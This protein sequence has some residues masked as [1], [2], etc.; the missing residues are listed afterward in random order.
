M[1]IQDLRSQNLILLEVISGSKS[2][3]LDTPSSDT[4]IKGVFY[5]PKDKF[6]GLEYIPQ[7]SNETNDIVYYELGRF[8]ELLLKN[9]PN[10]LEILATPE[11]CILYK[12]PIMEQLRLEDFLSKLCKD[13]FTG[14]AI[15]Q[16]KKA[17]TLKKKIV[18]PMKKERKSLLDFCFIL[19]GPTTIPLKEWCKTNT[20]LQEHC[21]L[22]N[23]PHSKGIYAVFYDKNQTFQYKGIIAN[24]RTNKLLLSPIPKE[25]KPIGYL[26]Y[27]Q[28]AYSVYC[29]EYKAYWNW[30]EKRNKA[31]YHANEQHGKHYDSKNMMHTIR[32]LQSALQ[33]GKTARLTIRVSNR[34]ELLAIKT[35]SIN[36]DQLMQS[37]ET[38]LQAIEEVYDNVNLKEK[39]NYNQAED[40]LIKMR[41][42][43]YT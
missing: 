21:G 15:T 13:T 6:F 40:L 3:G 34:E 4:D 27:N 2:F 31:R 43:L 22:L 20:F 9:N 33:I 23:I 37:A 14:Y 1:T 36:Y 41:N 5:L 39:P 42:T 26:Y 28:E 19:Q 11:D 35:G 29:K 38:L 17:K 24:E 30:V 10:I 12:H 18:N 8:V 32:L 25:E 7:I 16:I